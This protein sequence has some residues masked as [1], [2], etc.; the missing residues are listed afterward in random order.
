MNN[1]EFWIFLK[2]YFKEILSVLGGVGMFFLGKK[3]RKQT[4]KEKD[5]QITSTELENVEA[6]LKI[7]RVMLDDLQVKLTEA[8][9]AYSLLESRFQVAIKKNKEYESEVNRLT[10][11]NDYLTDKLH[12]YA[13][14]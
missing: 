6:A 12:N 5:A 10:T 11:E 3:A 7:Y 9:K 13:K 14:K 4:L 8:Q 1:F 2:G